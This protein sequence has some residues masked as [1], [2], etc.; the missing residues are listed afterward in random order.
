MKTHLMGKV[1]RQNASTI[2][3]HV[4]ALKTETNLSLIYKEAVVNT[5]C[6]LA[7]F[8]SDISFEDMKREHILSFL[9]RLRKTEE[10]DRRHRWIGTHNQNLIHINRFYKWLLF[11]LTSERSI[12][13]CDISKLK[14]YTKRLVT[15]IEMSKVVRYLACRNCS[16]QALTFSGHTA[17]MIAFTR[18]K[19]KQKTG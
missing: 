3:E 13:I 6:T 15:E 12:W 5:L 16:S 8:H 11:C 7:K 9:T 19:S 4:F 2:I 18:A 17:I 1:S 10:Q 14:T